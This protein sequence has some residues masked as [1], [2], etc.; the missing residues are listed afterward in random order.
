MKDI[1]EA[2]REINSSLF[3]IN[4]CKKYFGLSFHEDKKSFFI[5]FRNKLLL[6]IV[7]FI[8]C[9]HTFADVVYMGILIKENPKIENFVMHF[10]TFGYG[11]LSKIYQTKLNGEMLKITLIFRYLLR[12][13]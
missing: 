13:I 1:N 10:H 6:C 7:M 4:L 12:V 2:R 9:Y 5:N 11:S 8:I 3:I